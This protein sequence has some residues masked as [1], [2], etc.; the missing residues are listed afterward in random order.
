[1]EF[2][3]EDGISDRVVVSVLSVE[4]I[5]EDEEVNAIDIDLF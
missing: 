3:K 4:L 2:N 5:N 1:M